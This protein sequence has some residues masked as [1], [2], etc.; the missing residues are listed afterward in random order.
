MI[1]FLKFG[2]VG[3][4]N[5]LITIAS[6]MLLVSLGVNYIG[7]NIASYSLGVINSY[8]WN[9][10]W[11]FK[12]SSLQ[13]SIFLKFVIVN[14]ITLGLNTLILYIAVQNFNMHPFAGQILSTIFGMGVNY[15]LNKRWTFNK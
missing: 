8:Y 10:K 7:S 2:V 15:L 6:F 3:V 11:V 9:K 13:K 1:S 14:L 5:T 4:S 12:H